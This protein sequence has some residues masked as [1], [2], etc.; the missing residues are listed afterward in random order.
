M[1]VVAVAMAMAMAA[2]ARAAAEATTDAVEAM[3]EAMATA[4]EGDASASTML[5][6]ACSVLSF[7]PLPLSRPVLPQLSQRALAARI[8][9][10]ALVMQAPPVM[11]A[12]YVLCSRITSTG[13]TYHVSSVAYMYSS[14][15][16][17]KTELWQGI[18]HHDCDVRT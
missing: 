12:A 2:V 4:V 14:N 8:D 3:Q 11:D 10:S 16:T 15:C 9:A 1:N 17:S 18:W 7:T 6:L 13:T 5:A